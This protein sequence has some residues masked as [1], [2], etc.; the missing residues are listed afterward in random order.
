MNMLES[1][2]NIAMD[3]KMKA[4]VNDM[5]NYS[6]GIREEAREEVLAEVQAE[7]D[8]KD[9]ELKKNKAHTKRMEELLIAHNIPI[10]DE[11]E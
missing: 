2:Y 10:P 5:C 7:L 11:D 8:A 6:E 1:E 4:E 9:A 3:S